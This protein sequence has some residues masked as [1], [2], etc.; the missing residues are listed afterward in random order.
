MIDE[1]SQLMTTSQ[2]A[3]RLGI[4]A[5]RV[6]QLARSGRVVP[7]EMTPLGQLWVRDDVEQLAAVRDLARRRSLGAQRGGTG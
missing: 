3:R 2:V 4:S 6:R 7:R 1:S 5:E